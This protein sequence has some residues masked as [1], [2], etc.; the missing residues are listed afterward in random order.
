M[1]HCD[2]QGGCPAVT[3][4]VSSLWLQIQRVNIAGAEVICN[5]SSGA[6]R[7]VVPAA[8]QR[9]VFATVHGLAHPGIRATWRMMSRCFIWHGCT[10]DVL[11]WCRDCQEC[12]RR[13]VTRQ[14]VAATQAIAVSEK[15]FS[16][17]NVDLVGPLPTSPEGFKYIF[18]IIDR[19]SRWLEAVSVKNMEATTAAD[20]LVAGWICRFGGPSA[21]TSDSGTQF[22]S[23]VWEA[24][25]M[26]LGIK[27][28]TTTAFHPCSNG[29]VERAHRQLRD[30][31]RARQ[32]ANDWP[33]HLL[34]VLLGLQAAMSCNNNHRGIVRK[35][36]ACAALL[37]PHDD[38]SI[39]GVL[40]F[41]VSLECGDFK[42]HASYWPCPTPSFEIRWPHLSFLVLM[43]S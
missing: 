6:A 2:G 43:F 35:S 30:V 41:T 16:H 31:L 28:I 27:H 8:F 34:W 29:M 5:V 13:K 7:P 40:L 17:I 4:A 3:K 11:R 32:A 20:T 15:R 23:V 25:C 42:P 26:R 36:N 14:P 19:S 9:T 18:T 1:L 12:Q 21:V 33:E 24:L 38:H 39:N 10:A 37:Y 22:T